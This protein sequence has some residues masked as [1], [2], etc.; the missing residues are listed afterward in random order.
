ME[1]KKPQISDP[2]KVLMLVVAI[3]FDVVK[4]GINFIPVLGQVLSVFVGIF[5]QMTF[6]LWFKMKG[7]S[8]NSSKRLIPVISATLIGFIPF[9][10]MIPDLTFEMLFVLGTLKAEEVLEKVPG[11]KMASNVVS[12]SQGK[13]PS[14][15]QNSSTQNQEME[16]AA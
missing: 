13:R 16:E 2:I 11:G 8:Y 1:D 7:V 15:I 14:A 5:A 12:I 6:W 3:F 10:D 9:L 4:F